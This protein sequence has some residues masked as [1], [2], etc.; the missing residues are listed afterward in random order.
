MHFPS[1]EDAVAAGAPACFSD[2]FAYHERNGTLP[3]DGPVAD[4]RADYDPYADGYDEYDEEDTVPDGPESPS[5]QAG[6]WPPLVRCPEG[7]ES[8]CPTPTCGCPPF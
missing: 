1:I 4:A 8:A 7:D 3:P 6:E 2:E 5:E